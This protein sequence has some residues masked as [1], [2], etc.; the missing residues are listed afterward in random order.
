MQQQQQ[1][2]NRKHR[3]SSSRSLMSQQSMD[4]DAMTLNPSQCFSI[5]FRG[6]WTLDLMMMNNNDGGESSRDTILDSL[7][8]I[9]K[10]YAEQ[11]LKVSNDVLLLR[12]VWLDVDKVHSAFV[13]SLC[14]I[15]TVAS[16]SVRL[17]QPPNFLLLYISQD[18]SDTINATELGRVLDR[19]NYHMKKQE[20]H[21]V[22]KKFGKTIGLDRR[23]RRQGLTFEQTC[24]L[25]HKV[26]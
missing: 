8:R 25:L 9:L 18:K 22:Y 12:Y 20:L 19:I 6:D 1:Q 11:K 13:R 17:T 4:G 2:Q 7:D 23:L 26:K 5:I 24:T 16:V 10:R 21:T 14:C 3:Q 15:C